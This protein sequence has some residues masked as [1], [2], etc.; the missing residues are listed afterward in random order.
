MRWL[1]SILGIGSDHPDQAPDYWIGEMTHRE[2][3]SAV[4]RKV[5]AFLDGSIHRQRGEGLADRIHAGAAI[6]HLTP[7]WKPNPSEIPPRI[8]PRD[9]EVFQAFI[10]YFFEGLPVETP[11]VVN[12]EDRGLVLLT[13]IQAEI[14]DMARK[15]M[16]KALKA[17][18]AL[19]SLAR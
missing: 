3:K 12:V 10:D 18:I 4:A 9:L 15:G 17:D 6:A 19:A 14:V 8:S 16:V 13:T 1:S 7:C 2:V 5:E 11:N